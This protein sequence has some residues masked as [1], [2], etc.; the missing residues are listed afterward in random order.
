MLKI[1]TT[2]GLAL[3][4]GALSSG[5]T[6]TSNPDGSSKYKKSTLDALEQQALIN[7]EA[8][9][10]EAELSRTEIELA[11]IKINKAA[12]LKDIVTL[13]PTMEA[14]ISSL[15]LQLIENQKLNTTKPIVVTSFVRL[16]DF[17]KTTEFG[18]VLGES[19]IHELSTR[20]LNVTEFRG[21]IAISV[22][23]NGEYF[24]TRDIKKLKPEIEDTYIVVGT[25]SRQYKRIM[26]NARVIDNVTGI[27]LSTARATYTH[28]LRDDC[29]IFKDCRP[30]TKIKIVADK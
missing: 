20:G 7:R 2:F 25:Y 9:K 3:A 28:N 11:K 29:S 21:Q 6:S 8:E 16:D 1:F 5:C 19:M 4:I 27:V 30:S 26:V 17:K 12:K 14:T 13:Q 15:A 24:I 23:D 18:R 22:N 10:K